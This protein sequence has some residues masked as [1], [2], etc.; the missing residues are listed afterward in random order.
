M[1]KTKSL[2][3]ACL[4]PI[5]LTHSISM[6]A[7]A[8][9]PPFEMAPLLPPTNFDKA[10][11]AEQFKSMVSSTARQPARK[12]ANVD[13]IDEATALSEQYRNLRNHIIGGD[14]LEKGKKQKTAPGVQTAADLHALME[15]LESNYKAGQ[16]TETDAKVLAA[17]LLVMKSMRGIVYR[18]RDIFETTSG[19]ARVAHAMAVT[20]LRSAA[21]GLDVFLP[22]DQWKAG[23]DYITTPYYVADNSD[24]NKCRR[25]ES[26]WKST[27]DVSNGSTF[28]M[29]LR[30][31]VLP[32][33]M[34]LNRV[35][36]EVDF[37]RHIYIDNKI[38][39]G[40]A[41]F[42][43]DRDRFLRLGEAERYFMLSGTQMAISS[44]MGISAYHLTGFFESMD[45]VARVY[46]FNSVFSADQATAEDRFAAIR[47]H[48]HLFRFRSEH[49]AVAKQYLAQSY[50]AL[51]TSLQNSYLGWKILEKNEQ[52]SGEQ[53]NIIDPRLAGPFQR[54][55]NTGFNNLFGIV[56][57]NQNGDEVARGEVMSAVVNGEKVVVRL[58]EFYTNP[59][60][61]LQDFMP[62]PGGFEKG[63]EWKQVQL[64]DQAGRNRNVKVRNYYKGR[65]TQW[66][67]SVYGKY[68]TGVQGPEDVKRTARV[69]SQSWG[70]FVLGVPMAMVMM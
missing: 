12:V 11:T 24:N 51:K 35:L 14:I 41:R 53:R 19:R 15:T 54:I 37:N 42:T 64:K 69:L 32:P 62:V 34:E 13:V 18:M 7:K 33:M 65:P 60:Q 67:Y 39:F 55:I 44:I 50:E 46:G 5:L 56:G 28:Q 27:C 40:T 63:G 47:Q 20:T 9:L 26:Q 8:K 2:M 10:Y 16:Y 21:A 23:F 48:P 49:E 30:Q 70:G 61:S 4:A 3:I 68:F 58:K 57:I 52:N 36:A 45:S 31:E 29:W 43:S 1:F 6:G 25:D 17:Q 22:T 59:P 66:N 38:F